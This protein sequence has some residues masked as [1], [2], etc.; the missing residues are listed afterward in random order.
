MYY[1]VYHLPEDYVAMLANNRKGFE[2]FRVSLHKIHAIL[3]AINDKKTV[4]FTTFGELKC[5]ISTNVEV[6]VA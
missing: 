1:Q 2:T 3:I 4:V 5:F 6:N